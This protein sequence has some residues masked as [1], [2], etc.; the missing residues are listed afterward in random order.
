MKTLLIALA[1]TC[2]AVSASFAQNV[3]GY[4]KSN[5]T[6]VAPHYRSS[7]NGTVTDTLSARA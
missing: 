5:G 3:N 7:P 6:Y 4:F 2:A 1:L